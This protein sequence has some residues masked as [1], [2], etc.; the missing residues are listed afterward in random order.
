VEL[1]VHALNNFKQRL[2]G[3]YV[4]VQSRY[5]TLKLPQAPAVR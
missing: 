2:L 5:V 1:L 4:N 3:S